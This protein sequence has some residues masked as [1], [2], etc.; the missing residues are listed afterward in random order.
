ME[1]SKPMNYAEQFLEAMEIIA[2]KAVAGSDKT[3]LMEISKMPEAGSNEYT[4]KYEGQEYQVISDKTNFYVGDLVYVMCP[5]GVSG[6]YAKLIVGTVGKAI[7]S[8]V[9]LKTYEDMYSKYIIAYGSVSGDGTLSNSSFQEA[10]SAGE[11]I[12]DGTE[13][14]EQREKEWIAHVNLMHGIFICADFTTNFKQGSLSDI[15]LCNC[16]FGIRFSLMDINGEAH[17]YSFDVNNMQDYPY[18]QNNKQQVFYQ[19]I[20][21]DITFDKDEPFNWEIFLKDSPSI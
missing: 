9:E 15:E 20:D 14:N 19:K 4:A 2:N 12:S 13:T 21:K 16:N 3:V 7:T 18:L 6:T 17:E 5:G 11:K 8:G 10:T 1:N